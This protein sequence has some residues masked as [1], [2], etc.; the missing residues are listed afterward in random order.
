[1]NDLHRHLTPVGT[2]RQLGINRADQQHHA[3][4]HQGERP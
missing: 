4:F 3:P 2:G 1:M